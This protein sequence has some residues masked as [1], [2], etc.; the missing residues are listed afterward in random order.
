MADGNFEADE[1]QEHG[2]TPNRPPERRPVPPRRPDDN[3]GSE[4]RSVRSGGDDSMA[5]L[6]P[7]RNP[8]A[9][10]AYYCGVFGVLPGIGLILGPTALI[11]GILGMSYARKYPTAKGTGH[12]ITGI[13]LGSLTL[14][15]HCGCFVAPFIIA[16][17]NSPK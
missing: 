7:Y 10:A 13:I 17:L 3:F 9:L 11:L 16:G 5:S 14:V 2:V 1:P 6:I 15:G 4:P 8:K 12:A